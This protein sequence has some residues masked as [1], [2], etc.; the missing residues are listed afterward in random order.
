MVGGVLDYASLV[1]GYRSLLLVVALF[2][3]LALLASQPARSR[4][5]EESAALGAVTEEHGIE[6]I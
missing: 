3:G 4:I 5:A 1:V 6:L 2:Y